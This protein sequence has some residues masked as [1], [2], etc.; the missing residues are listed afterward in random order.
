MEVVKC[1]KTIRCPKKQLNFNMTAYQISTIATAPLLLSLITTVII[2]QDIRSFAIEPSFTIYRNW[3]RQPRLYRCYGC[4]HCAHRKLGSTAI[5]NR[6][7]I[8]RHESSVYTAFVKL[9]E[10]GNRPGM[11]GVEP[12][13]DRDKSDASSSSSDNETISEYFVTEAMF[14]RECSITSFFPSL[15][16]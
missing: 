6:L 5:D 11:D 10:S 13:I 7:Q 14:V 16:N 1:G 3:R 4:A 15:T 9:I 8:K 2:L 12:S